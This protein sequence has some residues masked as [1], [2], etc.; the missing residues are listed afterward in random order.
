MIDDYTWVDDL[1]PQPHYIKRRR[2]L[3]K[4]LIEALKD[5]NECLNHTYLCEDGGVTHAAMAGSS[6]IKARCPMCGV[7]T[8]VDDMELASDGTLTGT[9]E[10]V[11]HD[12]I[13]R[14]SLVIVVIS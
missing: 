13:K 6:G 1:P 3:P 9:N 8:H 14:H 4:A 12:C 7:L 2:R 5:R 10:V 11:C